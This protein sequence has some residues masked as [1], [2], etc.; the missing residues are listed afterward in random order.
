[1]FLRNNFDY[2]IKSLYIGVYRCWICGSNGNDRGGLDIHHIL[3]RISNSA[4]NSSLLCGYCHS[5]IKHT[6]TEESFLFLETV[7][8]LI[9][10]KYQLTKKDY[11]FVREHY[12]RLAN[13]QFIKW[14]KDKL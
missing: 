14:L 13:N 6:K 1:M 8:F 3:G 11:K 4:L 10:C 2:K 7:K 12:E 5:H 9:S